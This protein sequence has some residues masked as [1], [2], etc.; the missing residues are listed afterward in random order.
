MSPSQ[1]T[2]T[3][4]DDRRNRVA[5]GRSAVTFIDELSRYFVSGISVTFT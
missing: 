3:R 1:A 2:V 4:F 5:V